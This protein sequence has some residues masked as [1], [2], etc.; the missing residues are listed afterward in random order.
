MFWR[1]SHS[2]TAEKNIYGLAGAEEILLFGRM[3]R[4]ELFRSQQFPPEPMKNNVRFLRKSV[5]D[6]GFC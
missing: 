6:C 4:P 3:T 1:F 2:G 5:V